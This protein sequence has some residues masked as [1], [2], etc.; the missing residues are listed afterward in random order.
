MLVPMPANTD[1][2]RYVKTFLSEF[3]NLC[4]DINIRDLYKHGVEGITQHAGLMNQISEDGNYWYLLDNAGL[5][6]VIIK[7][8]ACLSE[9]LIDSTIKEVVSL[10][11]G[12]NKDTSTWI[13]SI[14]KFASGIYMRELDMHIPSFISMV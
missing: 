4:K 1:S 12:V 8:C 13:D 7:S 11:F 9:I 3:Q 5:K 14:N 2:T 10:M 6:E